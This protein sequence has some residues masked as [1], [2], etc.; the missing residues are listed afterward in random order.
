MS[1]AIK[2]GVFLVAGIVLFWI[3]LFL[4]GSRGQFFTHH[5][6]VYTEFNDVD[7]LQTGAKVRV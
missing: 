2:V 3:G 6:T 5:F 4:I 7:T 1:R